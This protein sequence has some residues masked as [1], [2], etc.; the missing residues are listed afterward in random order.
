MLSAFFA[1]QSF[2]DSYVNKLFILYSTHANRGHMCL[3]AASMDISYKK[4]NFLPCKNTC[5]LLI[6]K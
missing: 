3:C 2:V 6:Q 5:Y 1:L 4:G